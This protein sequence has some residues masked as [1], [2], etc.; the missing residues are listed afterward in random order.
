MHCLHLHIS[1]VS[2]DG[3]E[4]WRF[5]V[6]FPVHRQLARAEI[7]SR[8][9]LRGWNSL[10]LRVYSR[11]VQKLSHGYVIAVARERYCDVP[12]GRIH[13]MD[14][15]LAQ[16][17]QRQLTLGGGSEMAVL[18]LSIVRLL[19]AHYSRVP[20]HMPYMLCL[21]QL[22]VA[23][24][25]RPWVDFC[26]VL[27][28]RVEAVHLKN[29]LFPSTDYSLPAFANFLRI[30][31]WEEEVNCA[32]YLQHDI[33]PTYLDL[34]KQAIENAP[35]RQCPLHIRLNSD[36]VCVEEIVLQLIK[37]WLTTKYENDLLMRDNGGDLIAFRLTLQKLKE[38]K[39]IVE[40]LSQFR[41]DGFPG[42]CVVTKPDSR[43][44]IIVRIKQ[45][46]AICRGH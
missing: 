43:Q 16:F 3:L 31:Y 35:Y 37:W 30:S 12:I 32:G 6:R 4:H 46:I 42:Y 25:P 41:V 40:F 29:V 11:Y 2:S 7:E 5:V 23:I 27:Q 39:K 8:P 28:N 26:A 38:R 21:T 24:S 33:L 20:R 45:S 15:E 18:R 14:G 10:H 19:T 1:P 36:N 9:V 13:A 34:I 22:K 17:K 44:V